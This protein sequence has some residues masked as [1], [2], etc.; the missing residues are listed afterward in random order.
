MEDPFDAD[1]F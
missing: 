1:L